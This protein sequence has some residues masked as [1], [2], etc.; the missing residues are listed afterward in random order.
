MPQGTPISAA[1]DDRH[2]RQQRGGLGALPQRLRHRPLQ[3]DRFAE[4]AVR[5]LAQPAA[6]LHRQRLVEAVDLLHARDVL[7]GGLVAQ[8]HRDRVARMRR[9]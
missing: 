4:V 6:E 7:G 1:I 8:Q 5:Q 9:A 3:E 2:Q